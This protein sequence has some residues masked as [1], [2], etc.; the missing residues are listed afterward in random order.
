MVRYFSISICRSLAASAIAARSS[1]I[2]AA[3]IAAGSGAGAITATTPERITRSPYPSDETATNRPLPK[4]IEDHH[5]SKGESLFA[6][7]RPSGL[8]SSC[9]YCASGMSVATKTV[10]PFVVSVRGVFNT[11]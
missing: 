1:A 10:T 2:R 9:G 7:T 11:F 3:S 4:V 8:V 5:E 6:Q